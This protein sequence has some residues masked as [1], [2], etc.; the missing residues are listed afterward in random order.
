MLAIHSQTTE[1]LRQLAHPNFDLS[2]G[3]ENNNSV[4]YFGG[5]MLQQGFG[6][7]AV[8]VP[9]SFYQM[10]AGGRVRKGYRV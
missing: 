8:N 9:G 10:E 5:N 3:K 4:L 1:S 6:V 2:V 7:A